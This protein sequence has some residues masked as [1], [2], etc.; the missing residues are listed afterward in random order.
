MLR[1][2][3]RD[4]GAFAAS[5]D[6]DTDGV[7]GATFTWRAPEVREVLG[8]RGGRPFAAA[9]GVTDD[10]NWEGVTILSRVW[11]PRRAPPATTRR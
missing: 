3:R 10:G 4:D 11:P 6:A 7:E 2:L 8:R 5:Q 9:Y 1:E